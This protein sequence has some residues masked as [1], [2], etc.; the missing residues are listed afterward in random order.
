MINTFI[1]I[2]IEKGILEA[3]EGEALAEKLS[4][5][6]LPADFKSAHEQVKN[7]MADIAKGR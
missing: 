2:L 1:S 7:L 6:T 5:S 4:L 3:A